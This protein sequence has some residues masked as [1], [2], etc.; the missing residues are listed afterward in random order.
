LAAGG[1]DAWGADGQ[2]DAAIIATMRSATS[3]SLSAHDTEGKVMSVS[4][5]LDGAATAIDAATLGCAGL[6]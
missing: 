3:M 2:A 5:K 6:K 4:W 1:A